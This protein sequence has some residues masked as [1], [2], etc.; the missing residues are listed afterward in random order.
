MSSIPAQ[1]PSSSTETKPSTENGFRWKPRQKEALALL[2]GPARRVM[3]RGGSHSGKTFLLTIACIARALKA[4]ETTHTILRF[5]FNHLLA[6][7]INDTF[8]KAMKLRFPGV[9]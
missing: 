2:A 8:A 6:S 4:P 7:V 9:A 1:Q 3:L 5:R